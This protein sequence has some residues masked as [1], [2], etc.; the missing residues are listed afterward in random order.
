MSLHAGEMKGL[1]DRLCEG[2]GGHSEPV[3]GHPKRPGVKGWSV[4]EVYAAVR[5]KRG[6][7]EIKADA[8]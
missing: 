8:A 4:A 7:E 1:A 3:V 6:R 5:Q 2:D